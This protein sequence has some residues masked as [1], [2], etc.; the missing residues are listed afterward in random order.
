VTAYL[1]ITVDVEEEGLWSGTYAAHPDP[2]RSLPRLN[3]LA[4]SL[5]AAGARI[6]CLVT[7]SAASVRGA[8]KMFRELVQA[9]HE[10]GSH[11][12]PWSTPPFEAAPAQ[13]NAESLDLD[14]LQRKMECLDAVVARVCGSKPVSFRGGRFHCGG[15]TLNV[16]KRLGYRV[17]SSVVPWYTRPGGPD[18]WGV[19]ETPYLIDGKAGATDGATRILEVPL[20]VRWQRLKSLRPL[21]LQAPVGLRPPLWRLLNAAGVI[22]RLRPTFVG[23]AAMKRYARKALADRQP[24]L[25][26]MFHSSELSPGATPYHRTPLEVEMFERKIVAFSRWALTAAGCR[27]GRLADLPA[28]AAPAGE[29][30]P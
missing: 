5:A 19:A 15:K 9:G 17:D 18:Y 30:R 20:S 25:N 29:E 27:A 26:L 10:V 28:T 8:E 24:V 12:H 7:Y 13:T 11:L 1:V 2:P 3:A 23:L 16:L 21:A 6:S 22:A 14:L 4:A